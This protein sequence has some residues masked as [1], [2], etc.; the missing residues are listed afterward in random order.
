MNQPPRPADSGGAGKSN[1][2]E[3]LANERTYLAYVRTAIALVSFGITINRFSLFLL[4]RQIIH[5]TQP[6]LLRNAENAGIIMVFLG[7]ACMLWAAI[8]FSDLTNQIDQGTF[9]PR[10]RAIWVI[11]ILVIVLGAITIGWLFQR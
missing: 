9:H 8:H 2:S 3:H 1:V 5:N 11:S 7:M 10:K 6:T 4:E